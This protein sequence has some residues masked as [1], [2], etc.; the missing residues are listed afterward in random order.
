MSRVNTDG[1]I[2]AVHNQQISVTICEHIQ[3]SVTMRKN[4]A[5]PSLMVTYSQRG[6][7][8]TSVN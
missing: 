8:K 2:Q 6:S 1:N 4:L 7:A 3:C 5:L